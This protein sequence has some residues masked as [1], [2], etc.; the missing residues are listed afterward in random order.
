MM[1][2]LAP[3]CPLECEIKKDFLL[4]YRYRHW[5]CGHAGQVIYIEAERLKLGVTGLNDFFPSFK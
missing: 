1:T 4:Q 3:L 2:H 5:M